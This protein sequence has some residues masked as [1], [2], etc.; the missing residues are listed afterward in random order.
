M[1]HKHPHS[2]LFTQSVAEFLADR[3]GLEGGARERFRRLLHEYG[4]FREKSPAKSSGALILV[5]SL[6]TLAGFVLDR[7]SRWREC[8]VWVGYAL[9]STGV[10]WRLHR[11]ENKSLYSDRETEWQAYCLFLRPVILSDH[12]GLLDRNTKNNETESAQFT[13]LPLLRSVVHERGLDFWWSVILGLWGGML[14]LLIAHMTANSTNWVLSLVFPIGGMLIGM[15]IRM[16]G[17]RLIYIIAKSDSR[18]IGPSLR[19]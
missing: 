9:I 12:P 14:A 6:L 8:L 13:P 4:G 10:I 19:K 7:P 17:Q 2:S 1:S 16:I 3:E 5:T 18:L 11:E 15:V